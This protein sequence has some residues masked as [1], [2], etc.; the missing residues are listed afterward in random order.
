M[1]K[2]LRSLSGDAPKQ[3]RPASEKIIAKTKSY[4]KL[5]IG[6]TLSAALKKTIKANKIKLRVPYLFIRK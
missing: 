2:S 3:I 6:K 1:I 4:R 5:A